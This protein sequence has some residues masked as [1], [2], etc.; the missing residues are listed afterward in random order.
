MKHLPVI[1][2]LIVAVFLMFA[3]GCI[4]TA[5]PQSAPASGTGKNVSQHT[6][7]EFV[8]FV[9][10]AYEYA[11]LHGREEALREFNRP[12]GSFVS[13]ELY[14]FAYDF[15][16]TTL[17][18]P[19]QPEL[20]GKNRLD[21]EDAN[22]VRFIREMI[23]AA[24]NGSGFSTYVYPNP[25]HNFTPEPKFSYVMKVD[26]RWWLGAGIYG[27]PQEAGII[28]PGA[29]REG[30]ISYVGDAAAF[31]RKNG[32]DVALRAFNDRNGSFVRGPLYVYAFDYNGTCLALPYQPELV[33]KDLRGLP[34][35]YGV[36]FTRVEIELARQGGGWVYYH[37][38]NPARNGTVEPK[39]SYVVPV[40]TT[41]WIGAG[42]YPS[43]ENAV[44][45][46][47]QTVVRPNDTGKG[48]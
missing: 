8:A 25:A 36:N 17:A 24:R 28:L 37:Y 29:V 33:G 46:A 7:Q 43:D 11:K 22:R 38:P 40:D 19:F 14:I 1:G 13:G 15:N 32:K 47:V 20:I 6:G 48:A 41:W 34:D 26:D 23:A 21:A 27:V 35:T 10:K 4:Q 39:V 31:A 30:I 2:V 42:V 16:G 18:L 44:K 5:P 12:D 9:E 3:A 45:A